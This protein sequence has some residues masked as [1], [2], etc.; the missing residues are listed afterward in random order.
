MIEAFDPLALENVGATL[1]IELLDQPAS[2]FP[3]GQSFPG[4]GVYALYYHGNLPGYAAL[5]ELDAGRCLYPIYVGRAVRENARQGFA[6]RPTQQARVHAR[7]RNH[8]NSMAIVGLPPTDFSYRYLILNDAYI[9][10]A[11][12]VLIA[13]FRPVWNG[14][15]L[16]NNG[17]GGPRMGGQASIWDA[18]HPGRP[19]RPAASEARRW[20]AE[21]LIERTVARTGTDYDDPKIARMAARILRAAERMPRPRASTS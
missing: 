13:V 7:L 2:S 14:A 15:G 12:S 4:A 9:T 8:Q 5:T 16:G 17:V 19:G 21:A 3:L 6:A 11:E 1:A 20:E 18:L 10:L